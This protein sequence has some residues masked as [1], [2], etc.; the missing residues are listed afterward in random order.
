MKRNIFT[1]ACLLGLAP[2]AMAQT[3]GG[4]S[5]IET[6]P[7]LITTVDQLQDIQN[8]RLGQVAGTYFR[9]ENDLDLMGVEWNPIQAFVANFDG[10]GKTITNLTISSGN[11]GV[12]LFSSA[13]T[14]GVISNLTL[15]DASVTAGNWSAVL[16]GTNGNWERGGATIQNCKLYNATITGADCIGVIAGVCTGDIDGCEVYN[17]TVT[18]TGNNG[19]GGIVGRC[20]STGAHYVA[21]C[22]YQGTVAGQ[23]WVGGIVGFSQYND[24]NIPAISN[25]AFY[26]TV[27]A[28]G[29][30]A[31]GI[32]AYQQGQTNVT[33]T[34]NMAIGE[35]TAANGPGLLTGNPIDGKIDGNF[36][37]GNVTQNG[38]G[39]WAGGINAT[40]YQY[41]K[42][43]YFAGNVTGATHCG[44]ITGRPWGA[45]THCV[46]D[47]ELMANGLGEWQTD[48]Y[49]SDGRI[50]GLTSDEMKAS[51]SN[52]IFEDL[53]K[54]QIIEGKTTA[55]FA[56]Q[57]APVEVTNAYLNCAEGTYQGQAPVLYAYD[58]NGPIEILNCQVQ[59]GKWIIEWDLEM[60]AGAPRRAQATT[61]Q[62]N[63]IAKTSGMM[64]SMLTTATITPEVYTAIDNVVTNKEVAQVTYFNMA[65]MSSS[66]AFDG[67][68]IVV[69]RY[70][71]GT[72]T[73]AKV[74]K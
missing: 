37:I 22:L 33:I 12:G 25:N 55:F 67:V 21:N 70:T 74:M 13:N 68:N 10:N 23:Q 64:P 24:G 20:E 11:N 44:A 35:V 8:S 2:V 53:A 5:G 42:N 52:Y 47:K 38:D 4:G 59:D 31:A 54:W 60:A 61:G 1:L 26:G 62:V 69:T 72:T 71:D 45:V 34:N 43:C 7:Y 36:A 27:S 15:R 51:L 28:N 17:G 3:F 39:T 73:A 50:K 14:P 63:I 19:T 40:Q 16:V 65:G 30:A 9:L 56:N 58:N 57:T 66:R 32:V 48:T 29:E 46:W 41:T 49:V 6:D 18:A